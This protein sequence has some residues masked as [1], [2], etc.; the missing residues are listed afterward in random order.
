VATLS[1]LP[2]V[3]LLIAPA[4]LWISYTLARHR[5]ALRPVAELEFPRL[6]QFFSSEL[7]TSTRYEAVDRI[8]MAPPLRLW[9]RLEGAQSAAGLTLRDAYFV[10][11]DEL[12][13]EDLHAHELVH[14]VQWRL[15]GES[16]FLRT[17]LSDEQ[18]RGYDANRLERIAYRV[19]DEFLKTARPFDAETR[20]AQLMMRAALI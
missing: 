5:S 12:Q 3:S 7:L 16:A 14:V 6:R 18:D 2:P 1:A 8:P 4:R 20:I 11:R 10:R 9:S 17:W 15:M 19:Q 13:R